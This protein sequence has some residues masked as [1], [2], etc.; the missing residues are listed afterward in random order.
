[1][2]AYK[3][4]ISTRPPASVDS[5]KRV[6]NIKFFALE[7]IDDFNEERR[8]IGYDHTGKN[9]FG[10]VHVESKVNLKDELVAKMK[11]YRPVGVSDRQCG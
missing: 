4:Y 3:K 1:M 9:P 2:N 7:T 8:T 10:V 6:K 11:H 5:N